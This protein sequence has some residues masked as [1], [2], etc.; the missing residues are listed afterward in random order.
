MILPHSPFVP[1]PDSEEKPERTEK[2]NFVDMVEYVDKLVG[3]IVEKLEAAGVRDNTLLLFTGDNGTHSSI[4]S[5]MDAGPV[6]GGKGLMTDAGTRVPLIAHWPGVAP[7]AAANDD[8]IDFSDFLPTLCGAANCA[9]PKDRA[10][11]GRSFLPQLQGKQGSPREWIFCHYWGK[12]ARQKK[13]TRE[14]VR[15]KEWKLYDNGELYNIQEDLL[16][17]HPVEELNA[18]AAAAKK[19][20]Q[21]AFETIELRN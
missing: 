16:E 14:F 2:E 15:D 18:E 7:E 4:V 20:L 19:R 13:G 17:K 12:K 10:I 6:E 11:D 21:T 8:L 9:L 1:T 3:R 5:Q